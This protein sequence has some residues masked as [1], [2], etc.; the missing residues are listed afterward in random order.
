MA[1]YVDSARIPFRR[2][3]MCHM[4]ADSLHELCEMADKIG[5]Q[6]KWIQGHP[7]LSHGKAKRASWVH[8]DIALRTRA[9]AVKAGAIET[10]KYGPVEHIAKLDIASGDLV[11]ADRGARKLEQIAMMRNAK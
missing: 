6:R 4:W 1:V 8:F 9:K 5:L 3:I 7:V 2:M 10:D 11:L